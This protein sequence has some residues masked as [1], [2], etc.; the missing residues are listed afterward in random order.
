[1]RKTYAEPPVLLP[2]RKGSEGKL[3]HDSTWVSVELSDTNKQAALH[4]NKSAVTIP[5]SE[6]LSSAPVMPEAKY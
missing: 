5:L 4:S 2:P 6:L 1:M 3:H